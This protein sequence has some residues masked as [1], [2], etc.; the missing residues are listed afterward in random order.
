M[1]SKIDLKLI[2]KKY[3]SKTFEY[4][5]IFRNIKTKNY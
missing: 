5:L 1:T 2:V 3:L 4:K